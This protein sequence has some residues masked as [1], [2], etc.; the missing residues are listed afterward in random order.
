MPGD[1]KSWRQCVVYALHNKLCEWIDVPDNESRQQRVHC[2]GHFE[3]DRGGVKCLR[4]SSETNT[5]G[6][7]V[8]NDSG[9]AQEHIAE[10]VCVETKV[11]TEAVGESVCQ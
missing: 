11:N 7:E 2:T 3:G 1:V 8:V 9:S 5:V 10:Q 4:L 6:G